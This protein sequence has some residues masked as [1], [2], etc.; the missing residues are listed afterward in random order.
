MQGKG[1]R[2]TSV[3]DNRCFTSGHGFT[4]CGKN[5]PTV[6]SGAEAHRKPSTYCRS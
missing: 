2:L 5:L 3:C 4:G 1:A 6:S